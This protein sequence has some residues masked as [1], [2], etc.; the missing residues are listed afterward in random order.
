MPPS[1]H[2]PK[3]LSDI[4]L[5]IEGDLRKLTQNSEPNSISIELERLGVFQSAF[6]TYIDDTSLYKTVLE[7]IKEEYD[8]AIES[9]KG[10]LESFSYFE[11]QRKETDVSHERIMEEIKQRSENEIKDLVQKVKAMEELVVKLRREKVNA[12]MGSSKY[13]TESKHFQIE[14]NNLRSTSI[15]IAASLTRSE[16]NL[17]KAQQMLVDK[18]REVNEGRASAM[19]MSEEINNLQLSIHVCFFIYIFFY[20]ISEVILFLF[21]EFTVIIRR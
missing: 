20:V 21:V 13:A 18:E 19:R 1:I 14:Y 11:K 7:R 3:L 16:D 17:F 9:F 6:Q 10:K 5:K 12:E 15:A 2:R 8:N 4:N